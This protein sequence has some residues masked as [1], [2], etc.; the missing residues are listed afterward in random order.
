MVM[1]KGMKTGSQVWADDGRVAIR[2][3]RALDIDGAQV[4]VLHMREPTVADQLLVEEMKG[5]E[6]AKEVML[7]ANLCEWSPEDIKRLS[8]RDYREVQQAFSGFI[9]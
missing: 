1:K 4:Q 9:D 2:L 8:L 7:L 3:S 5:S 6:A